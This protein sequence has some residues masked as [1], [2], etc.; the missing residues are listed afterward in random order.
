MNLSQPDSISFKQRFK[1]AKKLLK[2]T[3]R[4]NNPNWYADAL[5]VNI[6]LHI[7]V[8]S[9]SGAISYI[10]NTESGAWAK[11]PNIS[12]E[13]EE[14]PSLLKP[15]LDGII[16]EY[17]SE[18]KAPGLGVILYVA[19]EFSTAELGPEHQNPAEVEELRKLIKENPR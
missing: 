10:R 8:G 3:S 12:P 9:D 7:F 4:A 2:Q 5:A 16:A 1:Q 15:V 18:A 6:Q 14:D 13:M 19:D 17:L 11:G